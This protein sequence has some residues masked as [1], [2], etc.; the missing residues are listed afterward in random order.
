MQPSNEDHTH[1]GAKTVKNTEKA[2]LVKEV[3]SSVASQYDL[4]NN[5]MSM[6]VHH[7]WK[8]QMIAEMLPTGTLLDL[9]AGTGDIARMHY[10][11]TKQLCGQGLPVVCCD[12]NAAML[13]EGRNNLINHNMITD[14]HYV[15]GDAENLP[16][17]DDSFDHCTIAFGIRNVT[18]IDRALSEMWR[19]LKPGGKCIILEFSKVTQPMLATVYDLYSQHVI[20]KLGKF[21]AHQEEAYVY[22][23]ESIRRFPAQEP[24]KI[25]MEEAGFIEVAYRNLTQGVV[26]IHTGW[27]V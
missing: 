24:F 19:V 3:F 22:L 11:R 9:A 15:C 1:F 7:L 10:E 23:V 5:A 17:P 26:A 25:M 16:F 12:I 14:V 8:K 27:K 21:I 20:P 4:M 2:S 18:H 13:K 6:G